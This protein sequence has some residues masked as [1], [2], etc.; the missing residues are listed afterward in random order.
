MQPQ[1][2]TINMLKSSQV[3]AFQ[4]VT[5][6]IRCHSIGPGEVKGMEESTV[7]E[8]KMANPYS[9]RACVKDCMR[10]TLQTCHVKRVTGWWL[11]PTP[12]KYMKV[13]WDYYSQLNGKIKSVPNHQPG[14]L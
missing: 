13:N 8:T 6:A 11:S 1:S 2:K 7:D 9:D 5:I 14:Q 10:L 3:C 4:E 12:L